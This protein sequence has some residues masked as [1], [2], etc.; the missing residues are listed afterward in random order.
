MSPPSVSVNS[1]YPLSGNILYVNNMAALDCNE[2]VLQD[3]EN[4][5]PDAVSRTVSNTFKIYTMLL[6]ETLLDIFCWTMWSW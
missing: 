2:D 1:R 5:V 4:I 3:V 6:F